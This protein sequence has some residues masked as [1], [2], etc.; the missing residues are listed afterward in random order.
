MAKGWTRL[1]SQSGCGDENPENQGQ[2]AVQNFAPPSLLLPMQSPRPPTPVLATTKS[3]IFVPDQLTNAQVNQ[4]TDQFAALLGP[5]NSSMPGQLR[6]SNPHVPQQQSLPQ[7]NFH[8]ATQFANTHLPINFSSSPNRN[9]NPPPVIAPQ[10]LFN[11][12]IPIIPL[13]MAP[14]VPTFNKP[15]QNPVC[16]PQILPL[17]CPNATSLTLTV[18]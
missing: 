14:Q 5:K 1:N 16:S 13:I 6:L 8:N 7:F 10:H 2:T 3:N 9:V 18:T 17:P 11:S 4:F 15:P 12:Q